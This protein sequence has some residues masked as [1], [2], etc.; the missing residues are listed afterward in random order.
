[1]RD[2]L[3]VS[4]ERLKT[5][6][7]PQTAIAEDPPTVSYRALASVWQSQVLL[8]VDK[9]TPKGA[10]VRI[11][12]CGMG[13][14]LYTLLAQIAIGANHMSA[15]SRN[16]SDTIN[17]IAKHAMVYTFTSESTIQMILYITYITHMQRALHQKMAYWLF[18]VL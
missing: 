16:T 12:E 2:V 4:M 9:K 7:K 1:M 6:F 17:Y 18:E 5:F 15:L 11:R 14:E 13:V 8:D 3:A 10:Q